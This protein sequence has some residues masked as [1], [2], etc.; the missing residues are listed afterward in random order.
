[1]KILPNE[2]I[3]GALR[4]PICKENMS[5]KGEESLI[6]VGERH[7]CFDLASSGYV[8]LMPP[9]QAGGGDS[10]QAVRARSAFLNLGHYQ[11]IADTLC[12]MLD[13]YTSPPRGLLIDAGCG[14]GYYTDRPTHLGFSVAGVDLSKFATDAAAKR[15]AQIAPDGAFF[16]VSSVFDLPF[17]DGCAQAVINVFAPCVEK[18][19]TRVLRHDGVLAVAY[20]GPDHLMGLK[21][22]IYEKTKQNE[23]RADLPREM[24]LIEERRVRFDI[25]V[26][27]SDN[28]QNLFA[29]TPYYWKTSP[30]DSAKLTKLDRLETTVDVIIA[31]YRKK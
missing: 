1:M 22:A 14:E 24:V 6:C 7:H 3:L 4:C 13:R 30:Q 20:A 16:S 5:L 15:A 25:E 31:L 18:E 28:L 8:N 2:K 11:P 26:Q 19:F 17:C 9:G 21:D 10:K 27:G 12:E 23:G 29:M